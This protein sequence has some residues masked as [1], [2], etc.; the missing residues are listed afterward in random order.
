MHAWALFVNEIPSWQVLAL[1]GIVYLR[2]R[3]LFRACFVTLPAMGV[4]AAICFFLFVC[5]WSPAIRESA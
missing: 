5:G 4:A 2:L 1:F 3:V